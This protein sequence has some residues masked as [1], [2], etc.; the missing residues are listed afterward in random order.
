MHT[1]YS[2]DY[3][4]ALCQPLGTDIDRKWRGYRGR[5]LGGGVRGGGVRLGSAAPGLLAA[6]EGLAGHA[7][8]AR[9][10]LER[11][12]PLRQHRQM[13]PRGAVHAQLRQ[14]PSAPPPARHLLGDGTSHLLL[15]LLRR[16]EWAIIDTGGNRMTVQ[17]SPQGLFV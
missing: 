5:V 13:R 6:A 14:E 11:G 8:E 4:K 1:S 12:G 10:C 2:G 7:G 16:L 17:G 15:D 3:D 9:L